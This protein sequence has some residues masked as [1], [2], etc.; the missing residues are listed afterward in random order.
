MLSTIMDQ[1]HRARIFTLRLRPKPVN[2]VSQHRQI[3][4]AIKAGDVASA[5]EYTKAHRATA[6]DLVVPLLTQYGMKFL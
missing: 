4:E 5:R 2:S 3:V 6:R 1:S